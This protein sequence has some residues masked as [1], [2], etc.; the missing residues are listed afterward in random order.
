MPSRLLH[1][2]A[3]KARRRSTWLSATVCR[4]SCASDRWACQCSGAVVHQRIVGR[5]L[6]GA[7]DLLERFHP[8]LRHRQRTA[9]IQRYLG[10]VGIDRRSLLQ[11]HDGLMRLLALQGA[12]TGGEQ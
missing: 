12:R 7:L 2:R 5:Q 4:R 10:V 11:R 9:Q 3:S 6:Q 8:A 1:G